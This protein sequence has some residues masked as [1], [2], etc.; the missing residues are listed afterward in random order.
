V[1][2]TNTAAASEHI[3][4]DAQ[5]DAAVDRGDA[6]EVPLPPATFHCEAVPARLYDLAT[7]LVEP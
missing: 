2:F 4:T 3:V 7:P 1:L 5:I 6:I